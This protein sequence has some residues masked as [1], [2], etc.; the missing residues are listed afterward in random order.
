MRFEVLGPLQVR[1]DEGAPVTVREPKVRAL[2]ADLLAH[3]G[4]PVST[5]R[6]VDDLWGESVPKNAVNT[7]QTKVSQ[8]RRA[9][10]TA[11]PGG[12]ELV[13]HLPAG[14]LLRVPTEAVDSGRFAALTGEARGSEDPGVRFKLLSDAL[15]LWR[16]AAFTEFRDH[17]F[18]Q[19]AAAG[20]EEQR[21]TVVEELAGIRLERGEHRLLADELSD[22]V[23]LH[24]LR[25]RVRAVHMRALYLSGRQ[26]EALESYRELTERLAEEL[27]LDPG[28][29]LVALHQAIL[30]QDPVLKPASS[31][32]PTASAGL[33]PGPAP[34]AAFR[35]NLPA[36]LTD[37]IGRR[38]EVS[39]VRALLQSGR[40]VTLVGP[41]GV[42]KTRLAL[43]AAAPPV[44]AL[45]DAGGFP[46]AE[47]FPDGVWLVELA[48]ETGGAATG[49]SPGET[50][51]SG[52]AAAV[53]SVVAD[54]LGIRDHAGS[55]PMPPGHAVDRLARA[56]GPRR[57][58]LV[59]DNCEHLVQPVSE[60]AERLLRQA[61]GLRILATS[62][63]PLAILGEALHAVEPL[64][65]S[66]AVLLFAARAA[67]AS[68]GFAL[69]PANADAVARVCERLDGIPLALEL[70]AARVRALGV[71]EL[72]ERLDDRFR[73]LNAGRRDAPARQRTLRAVIDW[74]WELL[75]GPERAVLRRLAVFAGGCGLDAAEEVCA[76]PEA[77]ADTVLDVITRLVDRSLVT[78]V[79]SEDGPRYRLLESVAAYSLERL[80]EAG[81]T[82]L[83]RR[84]HRLHY[85][86]LAERAQPW[87]Y[88]P[89][90]RR[91]LRRLDSDSANLRSAL[92]DAAATTADA[93][94][95][96]HS[97]A[98]GRADTDPDL[99]VR[100]V[101]ALAWYWFLR[102]RLGEAQRSFA[103]ALRLSPG[104]PGENGPARDEGS[105]VAR[106]S[107]QARQAAFALLAG[108]GT[109]PQHTI[110][111]EYDG[112]DARA[113]LFL[114]L[115]RCG[116][117]E[118]S[119]EDL[120]RNLLAEFRA[121]EDRWGMAATQSTRA[122]QALY[123]G[124]LADLKRYAV[125]SAARFAELDEGWG[126]LRAGEQL[127][128][129]AEIAGDY[130]EAT[131][132]HGD[133]VRIAEELQLWT[134]VSF[135]LS[136]LG[137]IALLT[138]E[139]TA[140]AGYHERARRLAAEQ[141]HR[142]AEQ[143][144][145]TGLA[146]GARRQGDLEGAETHLL[147][148]LEWNRDKGVDSGMALIL[149]EL[150]FIAEQRGDV[151][152]AQALHLEGLAAA[153]R[154]GDVRAIALALE[155]LAG[156]YA[157][158][159]PGHAARLLGTSAALRESVGT[160]LPPAERGDVDRVTARASTALDADT[161]AAAFQRGR[162][163]DLND[164]LSQL[165][166]FPAADGDTGKHTSSPAHQP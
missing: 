111:T 114:A 22:L 95:T 152:Q 165:P 69:G 128:V 23:R 118:P 86:L 87:L 39:E 144:A 1:T 102:G 75:T 83:A 25:D 107:A 121:T 124:D 137:R 97:G 146:L 41:G 166:P 48:A 141:L 8:L 36:R 59:L 153:R 13:V 19:A 99:A 65:E 159:D 10:E 51:G 27:G 150:G 66:D 30:R 40:L 84:R 105:R 21:L 42:G 63:E 80:E 151:L 7:L 34:V 133:G 156:A 161:F 44:D 123:R 76:Q 2:L 67:A 15:A 81:E 28:P 85:V 5:D 93:A 127:G 38:R 163:L 33:P 155:G 53:A 50:V 46:G 103:M 164:Q 47:A 119:D 16:G 60:L 145:T 55:A 73:L 79:D 154:T 139:Y 4:Q 101:N 129:L 149:A 90:Q 125:D 32:G 91:W 162:D 82:R 26:A 126:K 74:S 89:D 96:V 117:G 143:F 9:L 61:P 58:L 135:G 29:E 94:T 11:E 88:G 43:E 52:D 31:S 92:A 12:R 136:R 132:L 131:R 110:E 68:P 100:Q 71:H 122:T 35:T 14:Y 157:D 54:T 78:M 115:A 113:R 18:V 147:P 56:L 3:H 70:A 120:T 158:G 134:D 72:A 140:A 160:P 104:V 106:L 20:L 57:L 112:A 142:P 49:S 148:W 98:D 45:P 62:R 17:A 24:P 77:P 116:F 130:A 6:L 138:G 64:A 108:E 109:Q 37:L